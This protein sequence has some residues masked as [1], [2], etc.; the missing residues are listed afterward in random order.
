MNATEIRDLNWHDIQAQVT[1]LRASVHAALLRHGPCT[2][3]QLAEASG[4]SIL[5]VRP[6]VTE[7]SEL[8]FALCTGREGKEGVYRAYTPDEA[9]ALHQEREAARLALGQ[10]P[11]AL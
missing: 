6:R 2:T 3:R 10:I 9:E 8:G 4:L 1:G 11:L 5:T 7:L